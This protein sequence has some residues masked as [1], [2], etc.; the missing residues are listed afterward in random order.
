MATTSERVNR[1][2]VYFQNTQTTPQ[3]FSQVQVLP[4]STVR[5][6]VTLVGKTLD[7]SARVSFKR[8]GL[9]HLSG[10]QIEVISW[11]TDETLSS[12]PAFTLTYSLT[13]SY[14]DFQ[15]TSPS[16]A[17]FVGTVSVISV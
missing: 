3:T 14:I 1:E 16:L 17:S 11:Q 7:S 8:T 13:S 12:D 2:Y 6:E 9:F 15:V 4:G 5:V 10:P